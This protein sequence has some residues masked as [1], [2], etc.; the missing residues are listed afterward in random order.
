MK[1]DPRVRAFTEGTRN[2]LQLNEYQKLANRTANI[3]YGVDTNKR[4]ANFG[5]GLAGEAGEVCD[6]LKKVVFHGHEYDEQKLC[7]ELGDALWYIATIATN[8]GMKLSDV[9]YEN[10]N[11][12]R[13]RYPMGFSQEKS[14]NRSEY[15]S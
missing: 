10:V 3:I 12:L 8:A 9:A 7:L 2:L 11:K 5:M 1:E 15:D 6:Y 13:Q 4:F 14:I